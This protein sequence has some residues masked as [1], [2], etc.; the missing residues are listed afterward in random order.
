MNSE[1]NLKKFSLEEMMFPLKSRRR[2]SC[3]EVTPFDFIKNKNENNNKNPN[4]LNNKY[5]IND[6][7]DNFIRKNLQENININK[8]KI[9]EIFL[10]N[11]NSSDGKKLNNNNS[12]INININSNSDSDSENDSENYNNNSIFL[13]SESN[14]NGEFE[15][16]IEKEMIGNINYTKNLSSKNENK[17]NFYFENYVKET[18]YDKNNNTDLI[19]ERNSRGSKKID[20]KSNQVIY[21]NKEFS[22]IDISSINNLHDTVVVKNYKKNNKG[23]F[24]KF[25]YKITFKIK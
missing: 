17:L 10:I 16:K 1:K 12:N 8:I 19:I 22:I 3:I 7:D 9:N 4:I 5:I 20:K 23:K 2:S 6:N 18:I 15:I 25:Q 24:I 13:K 14:N 11:K 21:K